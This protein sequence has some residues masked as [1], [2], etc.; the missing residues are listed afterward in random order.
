MAYKDLRA[1]IKILENKGL[2]HRI[3]AEVDPILEI[4]EITD[5]MCKS[6]NG[7]KALFFEKVKGSPYPV[8]TNLFGSFD[9]MNLA[10]EIKNLD[11]AAEGLK[12]Y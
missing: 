7:G 8:V 4:S 6:P 12:N 10:L 9:R 3:S 2:I 5:R 1:F 11:D